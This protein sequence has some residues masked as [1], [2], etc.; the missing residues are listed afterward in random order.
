MAIKTVFF[1]ID[2]TLFDRHLAQKMAIEGIIR[3]FPDLF[4]VFEIGYVMD[5]F[6]ESD[7]LCLPDFEAGVSSESLREK[8]SKVFLKILGLN[9][10]YADTITEA[11]VQDYP[12]MNSPITGSVSLVK[13]LSSKFQLGVVS[14][15]LPDVQYRK[16]ETLGRKRA[17]SC[18]VLS[19]E[20][21][22]RKPDP[23]IFKHAADRLQTQPVD[24]LYVG[25]SYRDDVVGAKTAG[26]LACWYTSGP[27]SRRNGDIQ[28]DF[29]ITYFEELSDILAK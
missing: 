24:C 18:I 16:L 7:R 8:R 3:K 6:L 12:T 21:G 23:R 11:Y 25:D 4:S 19:E 13:E 27:N 1:D 15:G 20:F 9:E 29:V 22:I 17:F 5:V 26:M 14:N 2:G 10:G 28:A